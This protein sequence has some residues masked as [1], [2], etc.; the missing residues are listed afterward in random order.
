M[1]DVLSSSPLLTICVVLAL[2]TLLGAVPF[3]PVRFGAAGAL[4]IGLAFGALD[5]RLGENLALVQ[6]LGLALFVY[7]VGLAA[8]SGFFRDLRRQLPLMAGAVVILAIAAGLMIA[9]GGLL[10]IPAAVQAGVFS[11]ALTSTPALAAATA[12]SGGDDG[13]AV[14]YALT[15]PIG[16]AVT[17]L[18]VS[19]TVG[20]K[21]R[22]K[23]DPESSASK[24]LIDISVE[25]QHPGPLREVPGFADSAVRFSYLERDGNTRVAGPD[26]EFRIGDRV[27]I[28]GPRDAVQRAMDH[29]GHRVIRHLAEDRSDVDFRR[30]IVSRGQIAGR[31]VG[32]LDIPGRFGGIVT[33]I[34]RGDLDLLAADDSILELGDR[35]RVVL[36]R[37]HIPAVSALFG[38]SERQVSE[39]DALSLGIGIALGLL[40]GM[41]EIPLPGGVSFALGAAAGPLVV[42]MIL[43]RLERTGPVVWGLPKPAN[44]T[45]RQ[46]GLLL[47]LA[48]TGLASGQAF[49]AAVFTPL[50]ARILIAGVVVVTVSA[51]LFVVWARTIGVSGTRAAGA[52]PGLVGQ[53]AVLAYANERVTDERIDAGYAAI[54]ALG[55]IAKILLVQV[56]VGA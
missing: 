48:A 3:G 2:G 39:V 5:P 14:G 45:I 13:P 4:F 44:L 47:F 26:E 37:E 18:V 36:P 25:V 41:L 21:W 10:G 9:V 16:V 43:G 24:G 17:I 29:L 23:R 49:A 1:F 35:V 46:L 52:L 33:R 8:G 56:I 32:E 7:T 53:P 27:V 15:Y 28:V 6:K 11:G 34:R 54:F 40:L 50:G 19:Y 38:D 30:F 42:G 55:I 51:I 22:A 31:T 20:R 12:A